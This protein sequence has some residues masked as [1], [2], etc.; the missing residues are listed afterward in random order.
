M[1]KPFD[2][3]FFVPVVDFFVE[4]DFFAEEDFLAVDVVAGALATAA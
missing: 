1:V 4:V 2:V 3:D